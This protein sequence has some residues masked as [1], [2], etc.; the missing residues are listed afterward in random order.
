MMN[1]LSKTHLLLCTVCL[2]LASSAYATTVK[3]L[4][5]EMM[6]KDADTIIEGKV[7]AKDSRWNA[8]KN[9]IYTYTDI[10]ITTSHKGTSKVGA[11]I[12]IRQIGGDVDGISQRVVG[13][14]EFSLGEDVL[15]FLVK[16]EAT[17]IHF[18]VGMAQGKYA[19]DRAST[20]P[21]VH[22][23]LQGLHRLG[24]A[25]AMQHVVQ[26]KK[27]LIK[28]TPAQTAHAGHHEDISALPVPT[29]PEFR[30]RVLQAL[31]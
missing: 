30:T 6:A 12:Q 15:V 28:K 21:T 5:V 31:R 18:V 1:R 19:I 27:G 29:L 25:K 7:T 22:R 16:D 23:R 8:E 13:N 3:S 10:D 26:L 14:A 9:R 4:S 20:P 2:F 11:T 24:G 17:N